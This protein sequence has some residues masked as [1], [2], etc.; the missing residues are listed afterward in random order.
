MLRLSMLYFV[1]TW[2]QVG[3]DTQFGLDTLFVT[4]ICISIS[5]SPSLPANTRQSKVR[6]VSSV[7]RIEA[8]VDCWDT[9]G[10]S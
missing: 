1:R 4:R 2:S 3:F 7:M 8:L 9:H 10:L 6:R 5:H